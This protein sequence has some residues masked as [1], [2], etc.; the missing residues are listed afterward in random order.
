M[1]KIII[2]ALALVAVLV[3]LEPQYAWTSDIYG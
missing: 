1:K 2:G 3:V